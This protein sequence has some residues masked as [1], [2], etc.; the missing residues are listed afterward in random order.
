MSIGRCVWDEKELRPVFIPI[1]LGKQRF[2]S[3]KERAASPFFPF[4]L[5]ICFGTAARAEGVVKV[6]C[7]GGS[8]DPRVGAEGA[9]TL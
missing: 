4:T 3:I 5:G 2:L 9:A 1:S 6:E 7:G 8:G